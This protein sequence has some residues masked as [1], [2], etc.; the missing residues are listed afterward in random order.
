VFGARMLA[1]RPFGAG[2]APDGAAAIVSRSFLRRFL[3]GRA[4]LGRRVRSTAIAAGDSARPGPW[5]EIVGVVDDLYHQS[6]EPEFQ[7][8]AI[9][10][11]TTLG[12]APV[13][14]AIRTRGIARRRP[15]PG[16][17]GD[18]RRGSTGEPDDRRRPG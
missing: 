18:R 13:S 5:L 15:G 8:P 10:L 14:V 17:V 16:A 12:A 2:D 9:Y 7:R 1:G 3:G 11:P 4:A 6:D